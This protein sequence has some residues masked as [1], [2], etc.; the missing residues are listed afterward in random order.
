STA[1]PQADEQGWQFFRLG[2]GTL[3]DRL[4]EVART[5]DL[6]ETKLAFDYKVYRAD[7]QPRLSDLEHVGGKSGW[8]KVSLLKAETAMGSRDSIVIAAVTDD[9]QVLASETAE[10]LFQIPASIAA[11][12]AEYPA[13]RMAGIDREALGAAQKSAEDEN[14]KWLEEETV[15]LEAYAE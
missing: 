5:R 1:W 14:R 2:D 15:K 11:I 4:V 10:R 9:G 7:G 13:N 8:L 12:D 6:P 3:A